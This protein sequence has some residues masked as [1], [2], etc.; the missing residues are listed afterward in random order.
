MLNKWTDKWEKQRETESR[1]MK[2]SKGTLND[3]IQQMLIINKKSK[4]PEQNK[5][6]RKWVMRN[7]RELKENT[8]ENKDKEE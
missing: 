1:R 5:Q 3:G 7:R 8:E 6:I 4:Q 2:E